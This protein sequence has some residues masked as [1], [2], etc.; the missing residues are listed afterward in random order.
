MAV[1]Q[2]VRELVVVGLAA[3]LVAT[4]ALWRMGLL[5]GPS[6]HHVR[7]TDNTRTAYVAKNLVEGHGYTTNAPSR[8]LHHDANRRPSGELFTPRKPRL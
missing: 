5:Y 1:P 8:A 3:A 4:F 6:A 7:L 2:R